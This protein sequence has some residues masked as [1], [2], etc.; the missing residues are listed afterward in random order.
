MTLTVFSFEFSAMASRCEVRVFAA[1]EANARRWS[2][3]A[4]DE[5]RRIETRYSRYR[6]D[7]VTSAINRAAGSAPVEIDDETASL[8]DFAG[9]LHARSG[10]AFDLTSGVLRRAWDFKAAR[11]PG[12]EDVE[13]LLPLVGWHRVERAGRQVRL[14]RAGMEIDFGGIGK[15]YAADRAAAR[16]E[17]M[18]ARHGLVNL[19]GDVRIIGPHPDGTAWTIGVQDPRGIGGAAIAA[20]PV[21][22]GAM[23]TSG[24]YERYFERDGR[25]YCHLLDPRSGWP[26]A[27]WRS[28]SVV[29]P[30][31]VLAGACATIA[32]LKPVDEAIAFLRGEG[33]RYLGIDAAGGLHTDRMPGP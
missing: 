16:M 14:Q 20:L 21:A 32:M 5:V 1:D 7:S 19:G 28:V 15:E 9:Q 18:G 13:A 24:D 8:L 29:A 23:A 25:R 10:G 30:L 11:L 12:A 2:E 22:A 33:L 17:E 4:I 3:A 27:H 6:D 31:C 26:V